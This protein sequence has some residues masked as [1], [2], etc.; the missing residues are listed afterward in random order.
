MVE[1]IEGSDHMW[2][3]YIPATKIALVEI[4]LARANEGWRENWEEEMPPIESEEDLAMKA[5]WEA[6]KAARTAPK[7]TSQVRAPGRRRARRKLK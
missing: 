5:E 4:P 2:E 6:E 3:S 7:P 1:F